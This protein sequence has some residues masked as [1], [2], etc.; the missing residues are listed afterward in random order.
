MSRT[1]WS[2]AS[3]ADRP[4]GRE[5]RGLRTAAGQQPEVADRRHLFQIGAVPHV[6]EWRQPAFTE[7]AHLRF[8]VDSAGISY[9]EVCAMPARLGRVSGPH[10][11]AGA[12]SRSRHQLPPPG[13]ARNSGTPKSCEDRDKRIHPPFIADAQ[14]PNA[15]WRHALVK[16]YPI[17]CST[18]F[19]CVFL[20]RPSFLAP[21]RGPEDRNQRPREQGPAGHPKMTN[22]DARGSRS[23][24]SSTHSARPRVP[25]AGRT[26]TAAEER[27]VEKGNK[28][29][30]KHTMHTTRT[31]P[32]PPTNLVGRLRGGSGP[33]RPGS[34]ACGSRARRKSSPNSCVRRECV[35]VKQA[36][37]SWGHRY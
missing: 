1:S 25:P 11:A 16:Q 30:Q 26:K 33:K 9:P 6:R 19:L 13:S 32:E 12:A 23:A 36:G 7:A 21:R 15:P 20:F 2:S 8:L 31:R 18:C 35:W 22:S 4:V 10:S 24:Q 34:E 28:K 17:S 3:W 29:N 5:P 37:G 27:D 14:C